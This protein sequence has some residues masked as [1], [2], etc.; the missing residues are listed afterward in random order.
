MGKAPT[1]IIENSE[2]FELMIVLCPGTG[3]YKNWFTNITE[4]SMIILF[5]ALQMEL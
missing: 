5:K 2:V 4:V 1:T 3:D